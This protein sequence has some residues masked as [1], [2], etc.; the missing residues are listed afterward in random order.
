MEGNLHDWVNLKGAL[1]D[2]PI[3]DDT[4]SNRLWAVSSGLPPQNDGVGGS[5]PLYTS[6]Y[7]CNI[8]FVLDHTH[9]P[10]INNHTD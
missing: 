2:M 10:H 9:Q 8:L 4:L 5:I 1:G 3:C 6:T 7:F